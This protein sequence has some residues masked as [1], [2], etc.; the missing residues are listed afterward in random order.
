NKMRNGVLPAPPAE[1]LPTLTT[2]PRSSPESRP[3][4]YSRLRPLAIAAYAA[5]SGFTAPAQGT[6][7]A[8]RGFARLRLAAPEPLATPLRPIQLA[9]NHLAADRAKLAL[10]LLRPSLPVAV[11]TV[12]GARERG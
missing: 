5:E 3:V 1:R 9:S 7:S 6:A 12:P 10:G 2:G 8:L 11:A 4:S